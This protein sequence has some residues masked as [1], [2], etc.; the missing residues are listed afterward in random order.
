MTRE[1]TMWPRASPGFW[2][3][4][5][6]CWD[7]C[8]L[9]YYGVEKFYRSAEWLR[10]LIDI[11]L[12]PGAVAST[13]GHPLLAGF[14]F[15]HHLDGIVVGCRRNDKQMVALRVQDND[16]AEVVLAP[17][18]PRYQDRPPLPYELAI[19][20]ALTP[21]ERRRRRTTASQVIPFTAK[22]DA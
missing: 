3:D 8:C 2:C 20:A 18:D 17:G 19:D 12:R 5:V 21:R 1:G 7:G 4:W 11:F 9:S 6:P 14:S 10:Y 22:P 15:D 13:A 16:V